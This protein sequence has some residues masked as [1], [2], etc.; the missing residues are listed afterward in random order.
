MSTTKYQSKK[1][2]ETIETAWELVTYD[3]WG[4]ARDGFE[5]N[6]AFRSG[7]V[8]LDC[9]L[10]VYNIGTDQQFIAG[11]VS[12]RELRKKLGIKGTIEV[13]GDDMVYYIIRPSGYPLCEIRCI[14]H[15]SLSPI[16]NK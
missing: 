2:I 5:V 10:H 3:V 8:T 12:D 15:A 7:T 14:S 13:D 16:R 6:N 1:A 11:E 4:N 9:E